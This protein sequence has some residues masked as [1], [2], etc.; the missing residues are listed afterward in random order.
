MQ[1][2]IDKELLGPKAKALTQGVEACVHCGF[3][4][5]TC[6]T[7]GELEEEMNSPRGRIFLIKEVLE[8]AIPIEEVLDPIDNCLGCDAA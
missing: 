2:V 5:P 4:L 8:G 7:Y 1:H 3:C 6:P